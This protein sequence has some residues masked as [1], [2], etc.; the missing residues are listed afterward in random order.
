MKFNCS[1]VEEDY[2]KEMIMVKHRY[3]RY[4]QTLPLLRYLFEVRPRPY[5]IK[6]NSERTYEIGLD[7]LKRVFTDMSFDEEVTDEYTTLDMIRLLFMNET[8]DVESVIDST[9]NMKLKGHKFYRRF[10]HMFHKNKIRQK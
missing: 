10:V 9:M 6:Y 1:T 3:S 7:W 5:H 8:K 4:E 2:E